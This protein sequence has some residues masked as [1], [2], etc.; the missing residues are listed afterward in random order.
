MAALACGAPAAAQTQ[1]KAADA[2]MKEA[3]ACMLAGVEVPK[4]EDADCPTDVFSTLRAYSYE[5]QEVKLGEDGAPVI[6]AETGEAVMETR[7]VTFALMADLLEAAGFGDAL[8]GAPGTV[9]ALPDSVLAPT[10]AALSEALKNEEMRDAVMG[11]IAAIAGSHALNE[12]MV[13]GA[14]QNANGKVWTLAGGWQTTAPPLS[15]YALSGDGSVEMNG[16]M[17]DRTDIM[18]PDGSVI[19][20]IASP[21][22][23]LP[24]PAMAEAAQSG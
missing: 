14:F 4:A 17:L 1:A 21:L 12:P 20:I 18:A 7:N 15:F 8:R 5:I 16:V 3:P 2:E 22:V 13:K 19:H 24:Q 9:F 6:D 11:Q 23:A 10:V